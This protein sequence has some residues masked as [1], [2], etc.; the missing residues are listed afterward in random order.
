MAAYVEGL[1]AFPA[2]FALTMGNHECQGGKDCSANLADVNYQAFLA[3][4]RQ[5]SGQQ[6]PNYALQIQTRLG[7]ATLVVVADNSFSADDQSW[8][9]QTLADA[10]RASKYTIVAKHHPVT[11]SRPGPPAPWR[12]LSRHKYSL[13]LMG[14]NH[15]Y[16]HS[17]ANV[18]PDGRG[19]ICGLGGANLAHTGFCRVQQAP[20]GRLDFTQYDA[21]GNPGDAWSVAPQ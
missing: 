20:D 12:I 13:L 18:T 17:G 8:L 5:V 21:D 3:A 7:R 2:Y 14:H 10:D 4:L 19:V 6:S 1:Q 15:D 11:G 16:E 9:E